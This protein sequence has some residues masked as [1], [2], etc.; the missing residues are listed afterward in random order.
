MPVLLLLAPAVLP[1]RGACA[2]T[3]SCSLRELLWVLHLA[4]LLLCESCIGNS[5]CKQQHART[6][7][8]IFDKNSA[9]DVLIMQ[10]WLMR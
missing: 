6:Q 8:Q 2:R 5:V 3:C 7:Q 10:S 4:V 1:D 9:F